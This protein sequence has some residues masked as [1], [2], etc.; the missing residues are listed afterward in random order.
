M[1]EKDSPRETAT[2]GADSDASAQ[3]STRRIKLNAEFRTK[4]L[5]RL[6]KLTSPAASAAKA[7][8]IGHDLG[9]DELDADEFLRPLEPVA[10]AGR[11]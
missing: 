7:L 1:T 6:P 10:P 2:V 9:G 8:D 5:K 3:G 4:L 11:R